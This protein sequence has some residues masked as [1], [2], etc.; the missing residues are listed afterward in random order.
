MSAAPWQL[1]RLSTDAIPVGDALP[2]ERDEVLAWAS[3]ESV[4]IYHQRLLAWRIGDRWW[5]GLPG[6]YI[7][8]T[9]LRWTVTHWRPL[10]PLPTPKPGDSNG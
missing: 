8:L 1:A 2:P 9:G 10:D 3:D 7:D 6:N 5:A 4:S